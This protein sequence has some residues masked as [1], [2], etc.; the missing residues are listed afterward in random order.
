MQPGADVDS[1]LVARVDQ[2]DLDLKE[3]QVGHDVLAVL[4]FWVLDLV[5]GVRLDDEPQPVEALGGAVHGRTATRRPRGKRRQRL[6]Y[7]VEERRDGILALHAWWLRIG[8]Q[9]PAAFGI[10]G[11]GLAGGREAQRSELRVR[12]FSAHVQRTELMLIRGV[13][14]TA[15][16]DLHWNRRTARL[17]DEARG[18]LFGPPFEALLPRRCPELSNLRDTHWT[19]S[20]LGHFANGGVIK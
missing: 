20:P 5:H 8:H 10:V 1:E 11:R 17:G 18:L 9:R 6:T 7:R 19:T 4:G 2:D 15:R 3:A 12:E 16:G 13:H 14:H